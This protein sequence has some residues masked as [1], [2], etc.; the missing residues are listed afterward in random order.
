MPGGMEDWFPLVNAVKLSLL[1][2]LGLKTI[3]P[4]FCHALN[5]KQLEHLCDV[6][7]FS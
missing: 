1:T 4:G 3:P 5:L 6:G 2:L 7:D